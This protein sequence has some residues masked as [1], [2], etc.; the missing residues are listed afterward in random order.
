MKKTL[1][2]ATLV[3]L[4]VTLTLP[5]EATEVKRFKYKKVIEFMEDYYVT[6]NNYGQSADTIDVMDQY[7]APEF[8]AVFYFPLP[9]NLEMDLIN[10]KSWI[11]SSHESIKEVLICQELSV[12]SRKMTVVS[13]FKAEFYDRVT[14]E[15]LIRVD[16]IGF[17]TLK[18]DRN[19]NFLITNLKLFAAD[20]AAL[21]EIFF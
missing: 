18:V 21:M 6:F 14:G 16:A 15:I 19:N 8:V 7:W 1:F 9:E 17:Y 11:V 13:R 10:W 3:L 4:I 5:V 2:F 12:D 20:P